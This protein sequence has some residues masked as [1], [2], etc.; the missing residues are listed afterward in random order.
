M[1]AQLNRAERQRLI[2]RLHA[3]RCSCV[4]RNGEQTR[5]FNERGVKDLYRLLTEEP[6]LLRGA[7]VADKVVGKG[8]AALMILGS[9]E[10]V[11]TDVCQHGCAGTLCTAWRGGGMRPRSAA[12]RQPRPHGPLSGRNALSRLPHGRRVSGTDTQLHTE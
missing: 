10:E 4:I 8:A 3:E 7:F 6:E 1:A 5:T 11:Y 2:D 9:V 12:D